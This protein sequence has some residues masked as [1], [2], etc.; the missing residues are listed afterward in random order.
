[1]DSFIS[2]LSCEVTIKSIFNFV[3]EILVSFVA[4]ERFKH[5]GLSWINSAHCVLRDWWEERLGGRD[6]AVG[7]R[8]RG[9]FHGGGLTL[10]GSRV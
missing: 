3:L 6:S 10:K 9:G 4:T 8:A 7:E 1:M 5:P 2:L